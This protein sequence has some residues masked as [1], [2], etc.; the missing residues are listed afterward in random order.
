MALFSSGVQAPCAWRYWPVPLCRTTRL[1]N[2]KV[3][4]RSG[5]SMAEEPQNWSRGGDDEETRI[6]KAEGLMP[7]REFFVST[8][9]RADRLSAL[10]GSVRWFAPL[11][12][13]I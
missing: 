4:A 1:M 8:S 2:E 12:A 13:F 7:W 6:D 11:F 5:A 3:R 10:H 9:I